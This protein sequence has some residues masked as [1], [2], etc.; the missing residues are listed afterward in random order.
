[1]PWFGHKPLGVFWPLPACPWLSVVHPMASP[2]PKAGGE[3][4]RRGDAGRVGL[5]DRRVHRGATRGA[6]R[7]AG[8]GAEKERR[9]WDGEV[10]SGRGRREWGMRR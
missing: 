8:H 5:E 7:G 10:G 2:P 6:G 3:R 1:M 9:N 4:A